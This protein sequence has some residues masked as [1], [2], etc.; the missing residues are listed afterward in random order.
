[1][2]S[3]KLLALLSCN[4]MDFGSNLN[5]TLAHE[6]KI[7]R[8]YIKRQLHIPSTNVEYSNF[9]RTSHL[10]RKKYNIGTQHFVNQE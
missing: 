8:I 10:E 5:P 2:K 7:A 4:K 3:H 6:M 1:M 9:R